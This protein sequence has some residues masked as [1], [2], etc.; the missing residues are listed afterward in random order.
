MEQFQIMIKHVAELRAPIYMCIA[1]YA[2]NYS[3]IYDS[4][5]KINWELN[6]IM[7]EHNKYVDVLLHQIKQLIDDVLSLKEF[8]PI[9]KQMLNSLIEQCIRI[10]MRVLVDGYSQAKKCTNEG[11][12]LMQL[13]FQQLIVKLE[14]LYDLRP[15]PDKDFVENYIKVFY[16]P[17]Q[18]FEKWIK[19]HN[20]YSNKQI[21]SLINIMSQITRKTRINLI[22]SFESNN[23]SS[24]N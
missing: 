16:L 4:I 12:A 24:T 5:S 21:I 2:I 10:I 7:S 20:E 3:Q 13:D 19:E 6:D 11:R 23:N 9:H 8:L 15:I 1:R 14:K 22:N 17:E 18:S